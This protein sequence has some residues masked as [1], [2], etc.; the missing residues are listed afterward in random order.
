MRHVRAALLGT[1]LAVLTAWVLAH[2]A[3][4][5]LGPTV[6]A[7]ASPAPSAASPVP[8]AESGDTRSAGEAPGFV[9]SPLVAVLAVITLG[10]VAAVATIAYVRLTGGPGADDGPSGGRL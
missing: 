10:A 1:T 9:G 7:A 4:P 3:A 5:R 8:S 2:P 6:A